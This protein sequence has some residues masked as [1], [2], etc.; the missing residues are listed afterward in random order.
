MDMSRNYTPYA[1][2]E[3]EF[4]TSDP[5]FKALD[6]TTSKIY[7]Q[8]WSRA[9]QYRRELLPSF[10]DECAIADDYGAVHRRI[11]VR[12]VR[13]SLRLL[14]EKKLIRCE[15]HSGQN[16]IRVIGVKGK[17]NIAWKDAGQT[18]DKALS[19]ESRVY[20]SRTEQRAD[21]DLSPPPGMLNAIAMHPIL[22]DV[23]AAWN[24]IRHPARISDAWARHICEAL[25]QG[26]ELKTAE[27]VFKKV[28]SLIEPWTLKEKL[29]KAQ[30]HVNARRA[31]AAKA[32]AASDAAK[33]KADA[34]AELDAT[35]PGWRERADAE[36][37]EARKAMNDMLQNF[38]KV[39][40]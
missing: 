22:A 9:F 40:K 11:T 16:R 37:E 1:I 8:L 27:A 7:V 21:V 3:C 20:K 14:C 15:T 34:E 24:A 23:K 28:D 13:A 36:A 4:L 10:H 2:F 29:I 5:R 38:G 25:H 32:K 12:K 31:D 18:F 6:G 26:V 19:H 35:D 30:A 17:G 39:P 33:A